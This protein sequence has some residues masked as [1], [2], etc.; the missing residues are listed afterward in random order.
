MGAECLLK[1]R[2]DL[3]LDLVSS[4][5]LCLCD[6]REA[7]YVLFQELYLFH[8]TP[9]SARPQPPWDPVSSPGP[10]RNPHWGPV[11][12]GGGTCVLV[13]IRVCVVLGCAP[14][15]CEDI[16]RLRSSHRRRYSKG[17]WT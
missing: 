15:G 1:H 8:V 2:V 5:A 14:Y 16:L 7:L 12:G 11:L 17:L 9:P 3:W 4:D 6:P 10:I 13:C